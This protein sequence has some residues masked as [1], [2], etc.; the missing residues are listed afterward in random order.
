ML[1]ISLFDFFNSSL[2]P[3]FLFGGFSMENQSIYKRMT[4]SERKVA[5][6][7]KRLGIRWSF[8]QPVFVWDENDRPRVWTPDFFLLHFGIYVEVCGSHSFDYRYRQKI[9]T[10]NGYSVIFLHVYKESSRWKHHLVK[11]LRF[12]SNYR[13]K[14][15]TELLCSKRDDT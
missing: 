12:F 5:D 1:K 15:L 13:N 14:K 4:Y 10:R 8:E 9:L 3:F 7:L 6:V 11:Y 2:N